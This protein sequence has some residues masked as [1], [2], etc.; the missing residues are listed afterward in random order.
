MAVQALE[1]ASVVHRVS[2][3][4]MGAQAELQIADLS[5]ALAAA[6]HARRVAHHAMPA[7]ARATVV[8]T[9]DVEPER[10]P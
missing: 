5:A 8:A 10:G 3:D 1:E 6:A 2:V 7:A 4:A 9:A